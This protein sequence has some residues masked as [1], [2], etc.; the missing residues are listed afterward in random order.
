[1]QAGFGLLEAGS[2]RTKNTINILMKNVLDLCEYTTQLFSQ[3]TVR[4][5]RKHLDETHTLYAALQQ[6]NKCTCAFR[7]FNLKEAKVPRNSQCF[8]KTLYRLWYSQSPVSDDINLEYG[9]GCFRLHWKTW[10]WPNSVARPKILVRPK[11]MGVAKMLDF[12]QI[13]LF[14]LE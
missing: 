9:H 3:T 11:N 14:R 13:T 5:L 2:V 4:Y 8:V 10:C 7:I 12:R 6:K 1:M